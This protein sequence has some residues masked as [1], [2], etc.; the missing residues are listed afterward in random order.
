[1]AAITLSTGLASVIGIILTIIIAWIVISIPLYLAGKLISGRHTTFGKAMIAAIVAPLVT[2]FFFFLVTVGL[3]LFL[4][5]LSLLVGGIVAIAVL[6]YVY[7]SIFD[8]SLMGGFAIAILGTIITY[9][10]TF[11]VAALMVAV[12][13]VTT[14]SFFPGNG[15]PFF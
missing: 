2:L 4:G 12:F 9:V 7:A 5:P 15:S 10:M 8:T 6:S 1:M 3:A 14:N 13:G 11:I